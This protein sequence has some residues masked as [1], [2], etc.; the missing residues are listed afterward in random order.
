MEI[1]R[2][3]ENPV[4]FLHNLLD[5]IKKQLNNPGK[6]DIMCKC[7]KGIERSLKELYFFTMSV[8][9]LRTDVY[10]KV[11]KNENRLALL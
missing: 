10:T 4:I 7:N 2:T 1:D 5:N 11:I 8:R 6:S 3:E 9:Y